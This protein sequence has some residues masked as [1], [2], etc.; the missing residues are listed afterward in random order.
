MEFLER[1]RTTTICPYKGQA[2]Y[3]SLRIGV[4]HS[5]DAAWAYL[6]PLPECPRIKGY[7]LLLS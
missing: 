5:E 2:S 6:D 7:L 3:W 4:R 1:T